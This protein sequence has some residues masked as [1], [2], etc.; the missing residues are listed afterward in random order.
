LHRL[1]G[2]APEADAAYRRS[3]GLL[4]GLR[5][6]S[7]DDRELARHLVDAHNFHGEALR[8]INRYPDAERAYGEALALSEQ[9]AEGGRTGPAGE[10]APARSLNHLGIAAHLQGRSVEG[11]QRLY[12]ARD[13]LEALVKRHPNSPLYQQHLGRV[14][15]N[16][17][18]VLHRTDG[19]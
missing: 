17:T 5:T 19:F 9:L 12:Q 8:L 11:R 10:K 13:R 7:P 2:Q 4:D 3:I 1:L 16:L 14:Y 18:T 6:E 15:L